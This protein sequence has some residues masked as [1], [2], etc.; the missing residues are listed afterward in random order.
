MLILMKMPLNNYREI[1]RTCAWSSGE[2]HLKAQPELGKTVLYLKMI[3]GT[4]FCHVYM[5]LS[6]KRAKAVITSEAWTLIS[7]N[8]CNEMQTDLCYKM[9]PSLYPVQYR[10]N[11]RQVASWQQWSYH[12]SDL[13]VV[14]VSLVRSHIITYV[15]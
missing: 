2:E 4:S 15:S 11:S 12:Q 8:P 9:I 6:L 14:M 10:R 3:F 7:R 13:Q 1:G 5:L